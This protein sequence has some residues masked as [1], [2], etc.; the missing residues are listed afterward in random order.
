MPI[1]SIDEPDIDKM[2]YENPTLP[3]PSSRYLY[4]LVVEPIK[5]AIGT[6]DCGPGP[7]A[8]EA[9]KS[10]VATSTHELDCFWVVCDSYGNAD[11]RVQ[12]NLLARAR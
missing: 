12:S 8:N 11:V 6:V 5:H 9:E 2:I 7:Q 1:F 10:P 3:V 4:P